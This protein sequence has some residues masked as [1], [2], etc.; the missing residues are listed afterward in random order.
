M[1]AN[2]KDRLNNF[3]IRFIYWNLNEEKKLVSK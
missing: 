1:V 2:A 3:V